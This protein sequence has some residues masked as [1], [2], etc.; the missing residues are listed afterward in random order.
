MA[1]LK[2]AAGGE[3]EGEVGTAAGSNFSSVTPWPGQG[4]FGLRATRSSKITCRKECH[5]DH[6]CPYKK[7]SKWYLL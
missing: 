2:C 3:H 6:P 7:L 4:C 5:S 1:P